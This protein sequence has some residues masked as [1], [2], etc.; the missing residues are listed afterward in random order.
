MEEIIFSGVENTFGKRSKVK[1]ELL[2]ASPE[3]I[4]EILEIIKTTS[5]D[6]FMEWIVTELTGVSRSQ[7]KEFR[8]CEYYIYGTHGPIP[9]NVFESKNIYER[10]AQLFFWLLPVKING[11]RED[12]CKN[13]A[14]S[15][16]AMAVSEGYNLY[17]DYDC[18]DK[19][20][21]YYWTNLIG[22]YYFRF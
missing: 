9:S 8:E 17:H 4:L 5:K 1:D 7:K 20:S 10:S 15:I 21:M 18:S 16:I 12:L 19:N 22:A 3:L 14:K 6:E 11:Q 2:N 13:I